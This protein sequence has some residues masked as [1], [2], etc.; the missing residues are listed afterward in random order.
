MTSGSAMLIF[1]FV[2]IFFGFIFLGAGAYFWNT[3]LPKEE[4]KIEFVMMG[5]GVLLLLA[6]GYAMFSV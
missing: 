5:I 2:G 6:S 4:N 1:S 3:G